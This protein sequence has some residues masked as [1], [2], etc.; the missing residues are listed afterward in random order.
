MHIIRHI[1]PIGHGAFYTE[2]FCDDTSTKFNVV[3]D[4]GSLQKT[5]VMKEVGI[6]YSK[7]DVIDLLFIS[8]FHED[9]INGIEALVNRVKSIRFVIMPLMR[10]NTKYLLSLIAQSLGYSDTAKFIQSPEDYFKE[11]G[12]EA[13]VI[14]VSPEE[15]DESDEDVNVNDLSSLSQKDKKKV[16]KSGQKLL[17]DKF[18]EYIPFNHEEVSRTRKFQQKLRTNQII[19]PTANDMSVFSNA[20]LLGDIRK[21]YRQVCGGLNGNSLLLYSGAPLRVEHYEECEA[22]IKK[23]GCLYTGDCVLGKRISNTIKQKL[24]SKLNSIRLIQIP[25]H[26]SA[27]NFKQEVFQI[28]NACDI[29]FFSRFSQNKNVKDLN[30]RLE[31]IECVCE[32]R[33]HGFQDCI[34]F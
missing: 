30:G 12:C 17:Y 2:K 21:C 25:H 22:T 32:N 24:A 34:S 14:Y 29:Y 15:A 16:I 20:K 13:Q 10:G 23:T 31:R 11:K 3:Y 7:A 33:T 9:H 1:H 19:M 4:C 28:S 26:C 8:H 5:I 6:T 27:T 18:W